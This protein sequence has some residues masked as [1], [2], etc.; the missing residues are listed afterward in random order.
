M[1]DPNLREKLKAIKAKIR[2]TKVVATR[3]VKGRNGDVFLGFSAAFD[4]VQEDGGDGTTDPEVDAALSV[5]TM[6]LKE[7]TVASHLLAWQ[8]DRTAYEHAFAGGNISEQVLLAAKAHVDAGYSRLIR[9]SMEGE[10]TD[11]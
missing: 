5:G 7:A 8:A 10:G 9:Q 11:G 1:K 3:S 4:S 2:V 6:T